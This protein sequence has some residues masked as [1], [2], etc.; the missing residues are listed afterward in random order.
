MINENQNLCAENQQKFSYSLRGSMIRPKTRAK[1]SNTFAL[2]SLGT[3][4][5]LQEQIFKRVLEHQST[6][7]DYICPCKK[8]TIYF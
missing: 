5:E 1:F 2:G 6:K 4:R 3:N 7:T 8:K